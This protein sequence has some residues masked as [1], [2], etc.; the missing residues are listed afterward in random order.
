[1]MGICDGQRRNH[2]GILIL[3]AGG[4]VGV[5]VCACVLDGGAALPAC[6]TVPD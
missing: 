4:C 2:G 6:L 5:G 3:G 1:M